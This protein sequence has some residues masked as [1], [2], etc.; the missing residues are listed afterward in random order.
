MPHYHNAINTHLMKHT[1]NSQLDKKAFAPT[2][3]QTTLFLTTIFPQYYSL[4]R[5]INSRFR[6]IGNLRPQHLTYLCLLYSFP[7]GLTIEEIREVLDKRSNPHETLKRII[8]LGYMDRKKGRLNGSW[9]LTPDTYYLT[10][11]GNAV[12]E[13]ILGSIKR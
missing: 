10:L 2:D 3:K 4:T 1:A 6:S 11:S 13:S 8:K 5:L 9:Q 7:E 12:V